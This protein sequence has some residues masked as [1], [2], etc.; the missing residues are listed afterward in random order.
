LFE[1]QWAVDPELLPVGSQLVVVD[2][3]PVQVVEPLGQVGHQP[4]LGP[5][6]QKRESH[7]LVGQVIGPLHLIVGSSFADV[8]EDCTAVGQ[9][10]G[11]K[12]LGG[13]SALLDA[14]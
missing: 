2:A 3:L 8:G 5:I 1:Y 10:V 7:A 13:R 11:P 14:Y 9:G 4:A 12:D 6:P